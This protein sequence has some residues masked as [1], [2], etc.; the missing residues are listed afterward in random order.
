MIRPFQTIITDDQ[1]HPDIVTHNQTFASS[2]CL[3]CPGTRSNLPVI[4]LC[5]FQ[6]IGAFVRRSRVL[7]A[8]LPRQ[9]FGMCFWLNRKI[10][11]VFDPFKII[12]DQTLQIIYKVKTLNAFLKHPLL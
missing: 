6:N 3:A 8:F 11:C 5:L 4:R 10:G 2:K 7:E 12:Y 9:N 1:T